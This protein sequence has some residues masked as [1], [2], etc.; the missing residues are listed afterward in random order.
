MSLRL[1][2]FRNRKDIAVVSFIILVVSI[3]YGAG[4]YIRESVRSLPQIAESVIPKALE[5]ADD[6]GLTLPFSD[7]V[8]LKALANSGARQQAADLAKFGILATR[9]IVVIIIALVIAI[10]IF[11][12]GKLDLS[13]GTYTVA[14]NVYSCVTKELSNRFVTLYKSFVTVMGAQLVIASINTVFT[15]IFVLIVQLSFAKTVILF[16]FVCGL[17]P[18]IGNLIS[19]TIIVGIALTHSPQLAVASLI[20]LVV[21]HKGEYFLNSRIIGGRIRNPMWLTLLGLVIG[22]TLMGIPGM[23]FAPV[24]LHYLKAEASQIEVS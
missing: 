14:N 10:G 13:E 16:T 7:L 24:I 17:L 5:Y 9:E 8:T 12:N 1:L 19:N 18:I 11:L 4:F 6:Y 2:T 22:E 23:I 3:S 20:Y 21:L 15:A